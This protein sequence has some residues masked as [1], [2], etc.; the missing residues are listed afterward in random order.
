MSFSNISSVKHT[1]PAAIKS[2]KVNSFSFVTIFMRYKISGF[3]FR[4]INI[5][6]VYFHNKFELRIPSV[7]LLSRVL[8]YWP[9]N[10]S[11][12]ILFACGMALSRAAIT[13][14][15]HSHRLDGIS[16]E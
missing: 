2:Y 5:Y 15:D 9:C 8:C 13:A 10:A 3:I 1:L 14:S 12:I 4:L 11:L 16:P 6:Y 7:G